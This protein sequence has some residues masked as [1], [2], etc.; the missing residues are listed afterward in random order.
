MG[1]VLWFAITLKTVLCLLY[2]DTLKLYSQF[3]ENAFID[4]FFQILPW[5]RKQCQVEDPDVVFSI[6]SLMASS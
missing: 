6:L 3:F 1:E 4:F 5:L 2:F